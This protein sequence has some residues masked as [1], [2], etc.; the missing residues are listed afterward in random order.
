MNMKTQNAIP[1]AQEHFVRLR[2]AGLGLKLLLHCITSH[3]PSSHQKPSQRPQSSVR[4][5]RAIQRTCRR[6]QGIQNYKNIM[7]SFL[8]RSLI[9]QVKPKTFSWKLFSP[10]DVGLRGKRYGGRKEL[11]RGW[12]GRRKNRFY[13]YIGVLDRQVSHW[14][15]V[16]LFLPFWE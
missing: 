2:N 13:I 12:D 6:R 4:K 7:Q 5:C 16:A 8:R 9:H 15:Q 1:R 3:K 14:P 11:G 10:S